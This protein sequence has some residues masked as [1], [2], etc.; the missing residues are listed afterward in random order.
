MTPNPTEK[1]KNRYFGF[2]DPGAPGRKIFHDQH[3][4]L[5]QRFQHF[6]P[7]TDEPYDHG[8]LPGNFDS[9]HHQGLAQKGKKRPEEVA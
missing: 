4:Q 3:H 6:L 1:M 2:A 7:P 5:R 8:H 9:T